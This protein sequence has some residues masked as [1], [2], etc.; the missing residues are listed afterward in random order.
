M[1]IFEVSMQQNHVLTKGSPQ[2][3]PKFHLKLRADTRNSLWY[4]YYVVI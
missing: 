1:R 2:S 3:G 4:A